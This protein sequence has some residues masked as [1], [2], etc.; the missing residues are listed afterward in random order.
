MHFYFIGSLGP[1][2]SCSL[3][4]TG[5]LV[6]EGLELELYSRY[7]YTVSL[8]RVSDVLSYS[9]YPRELVECVCILD[10]GQL[11]LY[12][13]GKRSNATSINQCTHYLYELFYMI[14]QFIL[15]EVVY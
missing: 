3:S 10:F 4:S 6:L 12:R 9:D 1:S 11:A 13:S 15:Q 5:V 14:K 2:W 8:L 7:I